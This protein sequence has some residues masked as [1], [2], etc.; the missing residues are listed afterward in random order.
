MD[1]S[2]SMKESMRKHLVK[3]FKEAMIQTGKIST[4]V[5]DLTWA[6]K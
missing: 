2:V 3:G 6:K 4:T 5:V 1:P